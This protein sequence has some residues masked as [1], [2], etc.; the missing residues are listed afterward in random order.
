M[1][2]FIL[3]VNV[4]RKAV[5]GADSASQQF[6]AS[7]VPLSITYHNK[8]LPGHVMQRLHLDDWL[9]CLS[10]CTS[11]EDCIS[12]NFDKNLGT[13]ELNSDGIA[14]LGWNCQE[15]KSLLFSQGLVFHQIRGE[16]KYL[17]FEELNN[18][19]INPHLASDLQTENRKIL[20]Q[21]CF[22]GAIKKIG[23]ES[24]F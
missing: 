9:Q 24:V 3:L 2:A 8:Y 7:S 11:T 20:L 5:L 1:L 4:L 22:V 6:L 19:I 16:R 14:G 23:V 13:C 15:E 18:K 10:A 12:Y 21:C 17:L